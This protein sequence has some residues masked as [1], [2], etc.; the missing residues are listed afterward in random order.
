MTDVMPTVGR[1]V[2]YHPTKLEAESIGEGPLAAIVTDVL[3]EDNLVSLAVFSSE[4][5]TDLGMYPIRAKL[6]VH[7][8]AGAGFWDWPPRA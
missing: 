8:G 7:H 5:Q 2:H 6:A 3:G 4:I 1:L